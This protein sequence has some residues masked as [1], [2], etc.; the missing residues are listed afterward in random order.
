MNISMIEVYQS[1]VTAEELE[2]AVKNSNQ[3]Y[4][5]GIQAEYDRFWDTYQANG[6]EQHNFNYAFAYNQWNDETYKPKYPIR[7]VNGSS[8]GTYRASHITN[9]LVDIISND[10]T[11]LQLTFEHSRI[12][13]IPRLVLKSGTKFNSTFDNCND[14]TNLNVE[15]VIGT[16]YLVLSY[17]PKLTHDSLM[18]IINA[19]EKKTSGS[20]TVTLGATNLAK[21][22]DAEK[23]IAT[24]KG[25]TLA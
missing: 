19:L 16:N 9:T 23:A 5:N 12:V 2:L 15:G 18:S 11:T 6:T 1:N 7:F 8:V 4:A 21:L 20:W 3:A 24:E 10:T 17:C 13:T 25:W 14:L 22:T